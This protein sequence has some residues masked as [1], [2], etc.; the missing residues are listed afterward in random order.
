MSVDNINL[1][2]YPNGSDRIYTISDIVR[3]VS[4]IN[5]DHEIAVIL[6]FLPVLEEKILPIRIDALVLIL[7]TKGSGHIGIDLREYDIRENTLVFIHPKN[8]INMTE[9]SSDFS[10]NIMVCSRRVVEDV[11]PKLTDLLPLL[12]HHRTDP[13]THLSVSEAMGL[14]GFFE[15]LC[16]KLS[17]PATPFQH[18]KVMC[19]LQAALFEM[20]EI[21]YESSSERM[22]G[23]SRK[24]EIMAK[25]ILA[26]SENFRSRREVSF[27]AETLCITP[28][29]LSAVIKGITGRTAGEWIE[30]YVIM[31]AKV[32][33][34]STDL[35]IQEISS[36]LNFANQSF[37]GK[38]F[39]H[40][41]GLSPS[42]YRKNNS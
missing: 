13:V 24:E 36:K 22:F 21:Q 1:Q 34:K 7:C 35:T 5:L 12:I 38:Y 27:Y 26:V 33:L 41:T 15:F 6:D 17:K 3:Y 23:K 29:H 19:I 42:A 39:K 11:L 16:D 28:K 10:A 8:Y 4:N 30:N 31:E 18:R 40:I 32:L 20:M 2:K 25:F 14:N 9:Y 37:F